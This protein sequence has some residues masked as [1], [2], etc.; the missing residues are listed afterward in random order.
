MCF[1]SLLIARLRT[2]VSAM[3]AA[4]GLQERFASLDTVAKLVNLK[5]SFLSSNDTNTWLGQVV[6]HFISSLTSTT[7]S[8]ITCDC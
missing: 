3:V 2:D 5:L 8:Y 1:V 4:K 7:S 6:S